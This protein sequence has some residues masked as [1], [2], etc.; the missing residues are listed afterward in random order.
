MKGIFITFEGMDGSGKPTQM[1][2][3]ADRLR[4]AGRAVLVTIEPG[5]PPHFELRTY[6]C[7]PCETGESFL[8][9]IK[10]LESGGGLRPK[11]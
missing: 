1:H 10:S 2:R 6:A 11:L 5:G 7:V 8:M 4:A 9:A 3:L